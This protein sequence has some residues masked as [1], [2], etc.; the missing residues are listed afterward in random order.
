M[1]LF[2][3]KTVMTQPVKNVRDAAAAIRQYYRPTSKLLGAGVYGR[4]F[5]F[6]SKDENSNKKYAVKC[7]LKESRTAR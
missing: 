2:N 1:E 5:I 3:S 4:V 6:E 7:M